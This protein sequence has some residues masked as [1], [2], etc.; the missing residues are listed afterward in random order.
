VWKG[1]SEGEETERMPH[2]SL[3]F[4]DA[5]TLGR[6]WGTLSS[7]RHDR[8]VIVIKLQWEATSAPWDAISM[9][10]THTHTHTHT[11]VLCPS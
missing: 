7:Q 6:W 10:H 2:T 8:G 4:H 5:S 3:H 9:G 11:Q 1:N